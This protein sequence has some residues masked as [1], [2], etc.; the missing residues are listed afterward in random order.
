MVTIHMIEDEMFERKG[1]DLYCKTEILVKLGDTVEVP[2]LV[3]HRTV[4]IP[5]TIYPAK[6]L[7]F[8]GYG[9]P[10]I[11]SINVCGALYYKIL[12]FSLDPHDSYLTKDGYENLIAEEKRLEERLVELSKA[13]GQ[14]QPRE[15]KVKKNAEF[16]DLQE[17][18]SHVIGRLHQIRSVLQRAQVVDQSGLISNYVIFGSTVVLREEGRDELEEYQIVGAAESNPR[19]GKISIESPIGSAVIGKKKSS[20]VKV[21]TPVGTTQFTIID[22]KV[23]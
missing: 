5:D 10:K 19:H 1:D 12:E 6:W 9:M 15:S 22:I 14:T 11:G 16:H 3:G 7:R 18:Q 17:K 13:S 2:T 8:V 4:A 23:N 20:M 21:K